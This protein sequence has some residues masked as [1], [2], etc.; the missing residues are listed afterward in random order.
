MAHICYVDAMPDFDLSLL[1]T[2]E[3]LLR[4][5]SVT[6]AARRL[7][8]S[9][10]A[11]SRDLARLR[12]QLRDPILIRTRNGTEATARAREIASAVFEATDG[13]RRAITSHATFEPGSAAESFSISIGDYEAAVLMP[14]VIDRVSA[15]APNCRLSVLHRRRP[16]AESALATG[17]IGLAIGRFDDPSPLLGYTR[18]FEEDFVLCVRPT[19]LERY[20]G[21]IDDIPYLLVAPGGAGDF[22]SP[23][24]DALAKLGRRRK[25]VV[26]V[27]Y[28]LTAAQLLQSSDFA[29][30]LPRRAAKTMGECI[31]CL[32]VPQ[33]L[34]GFAISMLW[35]SRTEREPGYRWLRELFIE[36]GH[37]SQPTDVKKGMSADTI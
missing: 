30:V 11:V 4:E 27:P 8:R 19:T 10:P 31:S 16:D 36:A 28:F 22:R 2:L 25:I 21:A 37:M 33:N 29:A 23:Y 35:H 5:E 12:E 7:G 18:L 15:Q 3:A 9:Q 32:P 20:K 17:E 13:L 26:S 34:S 6:K 1:P 14:H 24:D